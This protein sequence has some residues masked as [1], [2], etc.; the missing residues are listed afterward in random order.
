[1]VLGRVF[2]HSSLIFGCNFQASL[3]SWDGIQEIKFTA[4]TTYELGQKSWPS[5]IA[6]LKS[7]KLTS[8]H[9]PWGGFTSQTGHSLVN[10]TKNRNINII[11]MSICL[12]AIISICSLL[13]L[14]H[15]CKHIRKGSCS[16]P[17][18][19]NKRRKKTRARFNMSSRARKP[20]SLYE[21]MCVPGGRRSH[22]PNTKGGRGEE[23]GRHRQH[24]AGDT[25]RGSAEPAGPSS[26]PSEHP[27]PRSPFACWMPEI[28]LPILVLTFRL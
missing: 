18:I 19:G 26:K 6:Q 21:N 15:K 25:A 28:V 27:R 22:S 2:Q 5:S 24:H 4:F 13:L 20:P 7:N 8:S 14:M 1:M 9:Q 16:Q 3:D 23:G 12:W 10:D 11:E 17:L